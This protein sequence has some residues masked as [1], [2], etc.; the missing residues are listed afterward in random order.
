MFERTGSGRS[1]VR[2]GVLSLLLGLSGTG[3]GAAGVPPPEI[4]KLIQKLATGVELTPDEQDKL[5]AWSD[6]QAAQSQAAQSLPGGQPTGGAGG[7]AGGKGVTPGQGGL[8]P[9]PA[10][11]S[12]TDEGT[13]PCPA[14]PLGHAPAA[15]VPSQKEYVALVTTVQARLKLKL[16]PAELMKM[17]QNLATQTTPQAAS[18]LGLFLLVQDMGSAGA[19]AI[20]RSALKTPTDATYANNLGVAL[21]G[22]K[23]AVNLADAEKVLLYAAALD[24]KS[25]DAQTNLG[26][27]ATDQK[28]MDA[29]QT[30]FQAALSLDPRAS[31]AQS[32][33]GL[34]HLC[35]GH[36]TQAL[37]SFRASLQKG[38]TDFA[39]AGVDTAASVLGQ[40]QS[41]QKA[42]AQ[43]PPL[44][45]GVKGVQ[46][47]DDVYWKLPPFE[48]DPLT[49]IRQETKEALTHYQDDLVAVQMQVSDRAVAAALADKHNQGRAP[50]KA[51]FVLHDIQRLTSARLG[52]PLAALAQAQQDAS[53]DLERIENSVTSFTCSAVNV[54]REQALAV[55]TRFFPVYAA[56]VHQIDAALSD[57]WALGS[58]WIAQMK[59]SS[60]QEG[61]NL[62]RVTLSSSAFGGAAAQAGIYQGWLRLVMDPSFVR[63]D[64]GHDCPLG[65]APVLH[66]I[67]L[68]KLKTFPD[69]ACNLPTESMPLILASFQ[70]DCT[71]I[72]LSFGEGPRLKFDYTFGKDWASDSLRIGV[73]AGYADSVV[74]AGKDNTAVGAGVNVESVSYVTF[75][76]I[77]QIVPAFDDATSA[78]GVQNLGQTAADGVRA[79]ADDPGKYIA[80]YGNASSGKFSASAGEYAKA[81]VN[82]AAKFSGVS[83]YSGSVTNSS[84]LGP[85]TNFKDLDKK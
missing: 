16:A 13:D 82:L 27:L 66:P 67:K 64:D 54:R 61:E 80:D 44:F 8:P 28:R 50:T 65:S 77:G 62:S 9:L 79:F 29:A 84:G 48:S 17:E 49:D 1:W 39:K 60:N 24:K 75:T 45:P 31:L 78:A 69:K 58:P 23:G 55:H 26:W 4:Q 68:G 14:A 12:S 6:S 53:A 74:L 72:H 32:G 63:D 41:G 83:D 11:H 81:E 36:P 5:D 38:F 3:Q 21:R 51:G 18:N 40:S 19:Y 33:V 20:S 30:Y 56:S 70:A 10:L 71:G 35:A 37:A 7:A 73:G 43:T 22:L 46:A 42:L 57:M 85:N 47:G 59:Y 52:A 2:V 34:L 76:G 25:A 15:A